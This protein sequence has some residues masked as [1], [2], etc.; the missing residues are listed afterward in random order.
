[1]EDL[2]QDKIT[3]ALGRLGIQQLNAMQ[4]A[5]LEAGTARDMLLLSPTGSGK[6]LAFL[7]PLL[8]ELQDTGR[9]QVLVVTPSRELALQI[10]RVFRAMGTG[11]KVTCCYGGHPFQTEKRSLA[12]PPALLI[13]TPGRLLD[14]LERGDVDMRSVHTVILDEFDKSLE[15]KF[16][17]EMRRLLEQMPRIRRRVLTSATAAIEIPEFV[18]LR[19]PL[20]LSFLE[21][22][23]RGLKLFTVH[24]P[25]IDK[26]DTL[27]KLLGELQGEPALVFCNYRESVERV[28][29]YLRQKQVEAVCFHGG[30]EQPEREQRL[31]RLA[32]GSTAVFLTTDLAARGLDI[33]EVRHVIH[34][35]L[36][37]NQEA[38]VHRNGRTAR[39]HATGTAYLLLNPIESMPDYVPASLPEFFLPDKTRVPKPAAW[40][41][42]LINKGKRDKLS[43]GDMVGFLCQKGGL[44]PEE[45]G[46]IDVFESCALVAVRRGCKKNLLARIRQEKIKNKQAKYS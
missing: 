16:V 26:L 3:Q 41:T 12:Q 19:R 23:P 2:K 32:N 15:M 34:Y 14:H 46:R 11:L 17:P 10:E 21:D 9:V 22:K 28:G 42:L 35:H 30:L 29:D 44:A 36:P 25:E 8:P 20:E 31:A 43:R 4:Q 1:M 7:L 38:F 40:E 39:M 5:A 45:V 27:Y 18:G 37:L 6:T 24:S 33:P 13:G